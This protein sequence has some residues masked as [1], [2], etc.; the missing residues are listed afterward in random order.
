VVAVAGTLLGVTV[1]ACVAEVATITTI[2][3]V[4][5]KTIP[6]TPVARQV[7]P[8]KDVKKTDQT[9]MRQPRCPA[10]RRRRQ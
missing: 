3:G 1:G 8:E 7:R 2:V 5:R 9:N 6:A 10:M 4:G